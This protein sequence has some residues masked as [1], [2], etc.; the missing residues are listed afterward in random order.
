[1][2]PHSLT[3]TGTSVERYSTSCCVV[4]TVLGPRGGPQE[5]AVDFDRRGHIKSAV[6]FTP[7]YA[8]REAQ[9]IPDEIAKA[10][11]NAY[12]LEG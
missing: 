6:R 8:F 3:V 4:L 9:D 12:A 11:R 10:A 7:G 2:K 1:M 5:W